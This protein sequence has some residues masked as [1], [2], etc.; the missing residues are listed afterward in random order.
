M[1][2][3]IL[4]LD[5]N[6][7]SIGTYNI[8]NHR[9]FVDD[10][11]KNFSKHRKDKSSFEIDLDRDLFYYFGSKAEWEINITN[12]IFKE[13]NKKVDVYH[14]VRLNWNIFLNYVWSYLCNKG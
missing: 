11:E 4:Y 10:C 12:E 1:E 5:I 3:N 8:F 13:V 6:N 7:N 9:K 2:W 14:Q